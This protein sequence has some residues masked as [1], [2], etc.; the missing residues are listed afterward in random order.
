MDNFIIILIYTFLAIKYGYVFVKETRDH[1]LKSCLDQ[2]LADISHQI[3]F[4][5]I[6][7]FKISS[8]T[9]YTIVAF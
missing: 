9:F 1:G 4:A 3:R 8:V 5:K 6:E 2:R 7:S